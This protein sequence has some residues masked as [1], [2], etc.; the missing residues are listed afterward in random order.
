[1]KANIVGV[2]FDPDVLAWMRRAAAKRRVTVSHLV[3]ELVH[4]KFEKRHAK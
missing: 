4:A 1:M 3:R 2:R